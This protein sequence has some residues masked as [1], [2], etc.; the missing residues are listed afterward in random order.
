MIKSELKLLTA[1]LIVLG[2]S[3]AAKSIDANTTSLMKAQNNNSPAI[4]ALDAR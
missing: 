2:L 4:I 3:L 1:I